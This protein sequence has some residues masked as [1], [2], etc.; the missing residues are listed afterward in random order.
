V[1]DASADLLKFLARDSRFRPTDRARLMDATWVRMT[2][3]GTPVF[4]HAEDER[5]AAGLFSGVRRP[6]FDTSIL[7][8]W[9]VGL[10]S[11]GVLVRTE[12]A[13][14]DGPWGVEGWAEAGTL[15]MGSSRVPGPT[16]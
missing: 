9:L 4:T 6:D 5:L 10:Y 2:A 11:R 8:P 1:G 12:T 13:R 16:A 7:D 14:N 3:P 15:S